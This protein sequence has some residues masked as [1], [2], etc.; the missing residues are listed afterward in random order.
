[1]F[2]SF[3]CFVLSST[4]V[5]VHRVTGSPGGSQ[6][7]VLVLLSVPPEILST[8]QLCS[9][10]VPLD[11]LPTGSTAPGRFKIWT[12][13]H[14]TLYLYPAPPSLCIEQTRQLYMR[15]SLFHSQLYNKKQDRPSTLILPSPPL[16][17]LPAEAHIHP[18]QLAVQYRRVPISAALQ[19]AIQQYSTQ[20][21]L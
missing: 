6:H 13:V 1:M 12:P 3:R 5:P 8:F 15:A 16:V 19:L 21:F 2:Y 4:V 7:S 9:A 20:L 18:L 11:A 17:C 14:L 10:V